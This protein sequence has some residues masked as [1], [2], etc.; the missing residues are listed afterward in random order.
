MNDSLILP[1]YRSIPAIPYRKHR[2]KLNEARASGCHFLCATLIEMRQRAD[3]VDDE[4]D[5]DDDDDDD[6]LTWMDHLG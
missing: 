2:R 5:D 1:Q 3:G 6:T 4:N